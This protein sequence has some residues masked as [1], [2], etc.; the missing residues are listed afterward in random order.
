MEE[1]KSLLL[2]N[3]PHVARNPYA[4]IFLKCT[5]TKIS[6]LFSINEKKEKKKTL[7]GQFSLLGKQFLYKTFID[8]R[9]HRMLKMG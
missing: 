4:A 6:T 7:F 2:F 9:R 8:L 5:A 1:I 3:D